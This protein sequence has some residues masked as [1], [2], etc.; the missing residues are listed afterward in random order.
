VTAQRKLLL[1]L[2][3]SACVSGTAAS[4]LCSEAMSE[5][6]PSGK[7]RLAINYGN[8]VLA[9]RN[10]L[11]GELQGVAVGVSR[12]LG[13]ELGATVELVGYDTVAKLV[14]GSKSNA[15]DVAFLAIDPTRAGELAFTP[16]YMEVEVTYLVPQQSE[17]RTVP[18]VDRA[19]VRIALQE[20]NAADLFLSKNLNRA[21][22]IRTRDEM[23]AFELLKA[24]AAEVFASNKQRLLSVVT[25]NPGYRV[26][27][28]R[29][30][31]I[32]H[33]VAVP[34][35][36]KA[37]AACLSGLIEDL[38]AS[39]FVRRALEEAGA[40]GVVV[41]PPKQQIPPPIGEKP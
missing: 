22:L 32:Q 26:L 21:S 27:E 5:L 4:D 1:A 35:G 9:S 10:P 33:A 39:G 3:L 23:A 17:L 8:P 20:K 29:F 28:G 2:G 41:A 31:A 7:L 14:A 15:W 25:S 13:R 30:A 40:R 18:D 11:T 19:G 34:I 37:A 12:Q 24:G 38:K 16:P 36:R 6:A